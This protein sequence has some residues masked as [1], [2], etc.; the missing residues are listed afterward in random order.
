MQLHVDGIDDEALRKLMQQRRDDFRDT[1]P[2]TPAQAATIILDGVRNEQWRILVGD[3]A[4]LLDKM[5]RLHAET[6][7]EFSFAEKF[8]KER[9]KMGGDH[10]LEVFLPKQ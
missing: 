5:V 10:L 4:H 3:D 6:A 1:A 2:L 7:Y 9:E 8:A